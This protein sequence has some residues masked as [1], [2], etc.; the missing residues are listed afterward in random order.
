MVVISDIL[1]NLNVL[2]VCFA[3]I[4]YLGQVSK[5]SFHKE[6]VLNPWVMFQFIDF[7]I[8]QISSLLGFLQL[9]LQPV[10]SAP[11]SSPPFR[12]LSVL[13]GLHET[14]SIISFFSFLP[15]STR[16]PMKDLHL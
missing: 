6:E 4:I 2:C 12:P 1:K 10:S 7:E 16:V 8:P 14:F 3:S 5:S 9:P 13:G 11:P 15:G